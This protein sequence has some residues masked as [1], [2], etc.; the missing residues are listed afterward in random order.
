MDPSRIEIRKYDP[1]EHSE[2]LEL[3][4]S[5]LSSNTWTAYKNTLN[6]KIQP[7]MIR[8]VFH[9]CMWHLFSDEVLLLFGVILYELI[10][11]HVV[12]K[13]LSIGGYLRSGSR[14]YVS[15]LCP[16]ASSFVGNLSTS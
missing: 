2:V 13:Y 16:P 8:M 15:F 4:V 7:A 12:I 9:L 6:G 11:Y 1:K 14:K 3:V 10:L 5:G